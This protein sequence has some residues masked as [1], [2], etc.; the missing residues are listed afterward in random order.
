MKLFSCKKEKK[1]F[2]QMINSFSK[3]ITIVWLF[4]WVET[5]LFSQLA[6]LF[7]FGD[8]MAIQ[9]INTNVTEIG[10]IVAAFYF[11]S[12]TF[13]NLAMGYEGYKIEMESL[14]FK[15]ASDD[16]IFPEM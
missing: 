12:K 13:E 3:W 10:T 6:T 5:V 8:A 7:N 2:L 1:T 15:D 11:G 16:D 4:V 9:S 14:K